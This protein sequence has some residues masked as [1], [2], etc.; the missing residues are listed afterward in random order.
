MST[1]FAL[2]R[3]QMLT[4]YADLKP[5]NL[6]AALRDKRGR[7]VGMLIAILF[8]IV[9]LG[10]ILYILETKALDMLTPSPGRSMPV[11]SRYP[12]ARTYF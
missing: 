8:L 5:K 11:V 3:L 6:K 4:R 2:L 10:V 9:Y 7:T 12:K 1:F